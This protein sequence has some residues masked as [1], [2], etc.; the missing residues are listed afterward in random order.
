M[1]RGPR[2][3]SPLVHACPGKGQLR[4][5]TGVGYRTKRVREP[6]SPRSCSHTTA[7]STDTDGQGG[8][9][10]PVLRGTAQPGSAARRMEVACGW[11]VAMG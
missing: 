9:A 11:L 6:G 7:S 4:R 10:G 2:P 8:M 5:G 1:A 3:P